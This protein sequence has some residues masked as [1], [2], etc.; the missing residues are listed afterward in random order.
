MLALMRLLSRVSTDVDSQS[1]PLD[2]ALATAGRC[3]G[4]GTLVGVNAVVS[5]QIG[6]PVEALQDVK[7]RSVHVTPQP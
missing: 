5:L 1:T 4:V 6:L 7:V 2:E 3:A